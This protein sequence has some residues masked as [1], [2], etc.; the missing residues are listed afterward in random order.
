[1]NIIKNKYYS[2]DELNKIEFLHLGDNVKIS[3]QT[4]IYVPEKVWI[5]SNVTIESFTKISPNVIIEDDVYISSFCALHG[6]KGIFIGKNVVIESH[7]AMYSSTSDYYGD[8]MATLMVNGGDF[9]GD[10]GDKI[11]V[12]KNTIIDTGCCILH[13][14]VIKEGVHIMPRSLVRGLI[15]ANEIYCGDPINRLT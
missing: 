13:G 7:V 15:K 10:F 14:S 5:G 2:L 9:G 11:V 12:E 8:Y 1:M 4:G 3:R 6:D